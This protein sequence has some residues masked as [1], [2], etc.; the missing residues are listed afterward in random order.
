MTREDEID[1]QIT[2]DQECRLGLGEDLGPVTILEVARARGA[3]ANDDGSFSGGELARVGF[4]MLG[5]CLRCHATIAAYNA[6]PTR[7]G[8]WAC[9]DC[10]GGSGFDTAAEFEEWCEH[11]DG[12]D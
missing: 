9:G 1:L 5:G 7:S 12:D 10:V 4:E 11:Q 6:H 2:R 8:Y 3:K